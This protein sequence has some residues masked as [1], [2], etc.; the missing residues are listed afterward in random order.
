MVEQIGGFGLFIRMAESMNR[1]RSNAVSL[2]S[3]HANSFGDVEANRWKFRCFLHFFR[4][5]ACWSFC[6]QFLLFCCFDQHILDVRDVH[7]EQQQK[8]CVFIDVNAYNGR[9]KCTMP[10]HNSHNIL[11]FAM[12]MNL[13]EREFSAFK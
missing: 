7:A 8:I 1:T 3:L 10:S 11:I 13:M 5:F 4:M 9:I 12:V 2:H 6:I